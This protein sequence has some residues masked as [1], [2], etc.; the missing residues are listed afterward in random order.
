MCLQAQTGL[1]NIAPNKAAVN[2]IHLKVFFG[3][4]EMKSIKNVV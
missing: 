4:R 1:G 2:G 3:H